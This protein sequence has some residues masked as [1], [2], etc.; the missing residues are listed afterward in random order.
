MQ[1]S[2]VLYSFSAAKINR[3]SI[4]YT[5]RFLPETQGLTL[6]QLE[7]LFRDDKSTGGGE[8]GEKGQT[9]EE[10]L[11]MNTKFGRGEADHRV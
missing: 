11:L 4:S 6:T 8:E 2:T 7:R 9:R 1:K 5:L 3:F 10:L